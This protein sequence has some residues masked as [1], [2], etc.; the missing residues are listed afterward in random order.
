MGI[1]SDISMV[2][3]GSPN[4]GEGSIGAP[5][6]A[7]RIPKFGLH[8]WYRADKLTGYNDGD[9]ISAGWPDNS[10]NGR[11]LTTVINTP[12][13]QTNEQNGK[14]AVHFGL[15]G[16]NGD[17]LY[18]QNIDTP[19]VE[20]TIFSVAK[21][22]GPEVGIAGWLL[23][24]GEGSATA[25]GFG[26]IARQENGKIEARICEGTPIYAVDDVYSGLT[27]AYH[28]FVLRHKTNLTELW[29]DN[30]SKSLTNNTVNY[31]ATLG[32]DYIWIGTNNSA[33]SWTLEAGIYNRAISDSEVTALEKYLNSKF[34]I[35]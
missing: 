5:E 17:Q 8:A 22:I 2:V 33:S 18:A 13:Y 4:V 14:P 9:T 19:T 16:A 11:N 20:M 27:A 10:G 35:Y 12:S 30:V 23:M 31:V 3:S 32:T 21:I 15:A 28:V 34:A 6:E 25:R 29:I 7:I 26:L 24:N 1:G